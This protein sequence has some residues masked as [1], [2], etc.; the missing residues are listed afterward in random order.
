MSTLYGKHPYF[1]S[2]NLLESL[3]KILVCN[4]VF[5]YV[6]VHMALPKLSVDSLIGSM[7]KWR[8]EE[9]LYDEAKME[10]RKVNKRKIRSIYKSWNTEGRNWGTK[11]KIIR[12]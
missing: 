4:I 12:A 6:N 2:F 8:W 1:K 10:V 5:W 11:A 7:K 3:G 9:S